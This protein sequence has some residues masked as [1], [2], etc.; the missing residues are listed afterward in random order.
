MVHE[1]RLVTVT[2]SRETGVNAPYIAERAAQSL[3]WDWLDWNAISRTATSEPGPQEDP[4]Q[5]F[6]RARIAEDLELHSD[7]EWAIA[8]PKSLPYLISRSIPQT[9]EEL[10]FEEGRE[11]LGH[12]DIARRIARVCE[13][14]HERGKIIL[15]G[16]GLNFALRE[17]AGAF[18]IRLIAPVEWRIAE[19]AGREA[20]SHEETAALVKQSD[21]QR[22]W[23]VRALFDIDWA[24]PQ[25]YHLV[26]DVADLGYDGAA[27]RLVEAVT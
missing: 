15:V 23:F 12:P 14:L 4:L 13:A 6:L 11:S 9:E 27:D 16:H 20:L 5:R 8:S 2:I 21:T 18:H 17:C 3:G 22:R 26:L 19:F 10:S 25:F 7:L 24:D 1:D